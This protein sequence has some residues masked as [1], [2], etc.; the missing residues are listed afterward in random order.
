MS[1]NSENQKTP[2]RKEKNKG[3]DIDRSAMQ[4][5][6]VVVRCRPLNSR[7]KSENVASIV[8]CLTDR[9]EVQVKQ[10]QRPVPKTYTFDRV[11]CI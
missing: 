5:V 9:K 2:R 6:Q 11:S 7:E 1:K 3:M 8:S 10:K 4:Q